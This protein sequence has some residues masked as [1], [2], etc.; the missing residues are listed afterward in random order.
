MRD[1]FFLFGLPCGKEELSAILPKKNS[2][3]FL[4]FEVF[5]L[6]YTVVDQRNTQAVRHGSAKLFHQIQRQRGTAGPIPVHKTH[7]RVQPHAFQCRGTVAR[8]QHIGKG[9]QGIHVVG[10]RTAIPAVKEKIRLLVED[11]FVKNAE[12][13]DGGFPFQPAQGVQI[14]FRFDGGQ[15]PGQRL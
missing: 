4:P 14:C 7:V 13:S 3:A 12:V 10:G 9:K 15:Q 5:V 2:A 11:H 1:L 6:Q 8:K